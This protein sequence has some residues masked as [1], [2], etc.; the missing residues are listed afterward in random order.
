MHA[1]HRW[2]GSHLRGLRSASRSAGRRGMPT[3]PTQTMTRRPPT[4]RR[5]LISS[6]TSGPLVSA[7]AVGLGQL[8]L[9][10]AG[11]GPAHSLP[12]SH[13]GRASPSPSRDEDVLTGCDPQ[14]APRGPR[15]PA[16]SSHH[17]HGSYTHAHPQEL[18]AP[19]PGPRPPGLAARQQ[20]L[21]GPP[22][23][24]P[25]VAGRD[26]SLP[27]PQG[28]PFTWVFMASPQEECGP[29]HTP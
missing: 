21:C 16:P 17:A 18:P 13:A 24:R 8:G 11:S 28:T 6:Q 4:W 5:I 9:P 23:G 20:Q 27:R 29:P 14:R 25:E 19:G 22:A 7:W 12:G 1:G 2:L 26:P 10:Q 15:Q 3:G